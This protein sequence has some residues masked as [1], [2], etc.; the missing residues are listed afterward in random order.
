M[1]VGGAGLAHDCGLSRAIGW[2]LE[3]L[4]VLAMWAKK[5]CLAQDFKQCAIV[6]RSIKTYLSMDA[7]T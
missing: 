2:F 3:P 4:L 5:V 7:L 6:V 1:I